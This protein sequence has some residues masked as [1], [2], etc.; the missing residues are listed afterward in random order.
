MRSLQGQLSGLS[1]ELRKWATTLVLSGLAVLTL[2]LPARSQ[3]NLGHISGTVT[4][5][6]GGAIAGGAVTVIDVERG[7]SRQV[8]TDAAGQ[9]SAP[10]LT[11][12]TYTVRAEFKGFRVTER[13]GIMVGVGQ[14]IRVD[15]SMQPG[16][17]T[18]TVTV[19]GEPPMINTTN[20]QLGGTLDNQTINEI[21]LN[22]RQFRN[23]LSFKP[24]VTANPGTGNNKS[25][26]SNGNRPEGTVYMLDGLY[27]N[28]IFS[29]MPI[30]GGSTSGGGPDQATILPLDA[31]QEIN[32]IENPKAEYGW[33]PGAQVNVGLK[34]GTNSIHGTAFAFGRDAAFDARD[35]FLPAS[36]PKAPINFEQF[37]ASIGGPIKKDK[38]FYFGDYE[39]QRL[40]AGAPI[41]YQVPTSQPGATK[42]DSFPDAIADLKSHGLTP[43]PLSLNLAGC[44][45]AGVCTASSGVFGNSNPTQVYP[46]DF[47]LS[48]GSNNAIEKIDY[49]LND[50]NSLNGEYFFGQSTFIY[51]HLAIQPYWFTDLYARAQMVRGV[52]LWTP[53]S[54]VVNEARFGYDNTNL[55]NDNAECT[56]PGS[57]PN[58]ATA[59]GFVSGAQYCGFPQLTISGFEILGGS[60]NPQ[61]NHFGVFA[62]SDSV[63]Y[64]HGKHLFKFGGEVHRDSWCCAQRSSGTGTLQF[65]ATTVN[66]V[67]VSALEAFLL[68]VQQASATQVLIGNPNRQISSKAFALFFQDD[69]RLTTRLTVSMGLRWE[70]DA[71][72]REA[73]NLLG[74]FDPNA[75]S[76]L[77]QE[78]SSNTVYNGD[79]KDFGPRLGLAWD[80]TGKGTTVVR[81]GGTIVG[82]FCCNIQSLVGLGGSTAS[83]NAIP[84]GFALFAANGSVVPSPGTITAGL[85]NEPITWALNT[86]VFNTTATAL[87]CGNGLGSVNT[88]GPV[89]GTNPAN[90]GPCNLGAVNPNMRRGYVTTWTLGIQHA[91]QNN[92]TMD[93]A[94]V[95]NHGTKLN[96]PTDVNAP[97]PGQ[98]ITSIT[99]ATGPVLTEQLRRPYYHE[100]PYFGKIIYWTDGYESNYDGLQASLTQRNSHG[101]TFVAG[102]TYAHALDQASSESQNS[103]FGLMNPLNP[104]LDYGDSSFDV[105]HNFTLAATYLIPGIKSPGQ[106][107][108]DGRLVQP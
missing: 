71:P 58:Y 98:K 41:V 12:G 72:I 32:V 60:A 94:Y 89:S 64:T 31:I 70:Y 83:L 15:I 33:R 43:S 23:I 21:P 13:T 27:D 63:S 46:T 66:G 35:Y 65:A 100:F 19:T 3:L 85:A 2:A 75:P 14:E 48:G 56:N 74:N 73:N 30:V 50:H 79:F 91:I 101:M 20:A 42:A 81:A 55:P 53:N 49:H 62:G 97:A 38:L 107:L 67:S 96:G 6:S 40:F 57:G 26:E 36:L 76:G 28:N 80:V 68:G 25:F 16:E 84:T 29:G 52:W 104:K 108:K 51:P 54:N 1:G 88:T 59:F 103:V 8:T 10:G 47:N 5:Q 11:P 45:S 22:G 9:Y 95:G 18:Q 39:G 7:V 102:Y 86:P 4:D 78:T 87:K 106:V 90:S 105:R 37:G 17:Q 77:T 92:L 34:S 44:T 93:V 99:A 82:N 69:W 24:G 61:A